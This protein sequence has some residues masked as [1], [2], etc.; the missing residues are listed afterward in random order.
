MTP[1]GG[2]KSAMVAS[3]MTTKGRTTIPKEIRNLLKLKA[4]GK[5]FWHIEGG[6]VVV[7]AKNRL[8]MDLAGMLYRPGQRPISLDEMDEAISQAAVSRSSADKP[9]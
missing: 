2:K 4:G 3:T 6:R 8:I 7:R 9:E 1:K 5:V